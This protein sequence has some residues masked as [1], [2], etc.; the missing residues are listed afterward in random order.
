M[1]ALLATLTKPAPQ[2]TLDQTA[3]FLALAKMDIVMPN[4]PETEHVL[5]VSRTNGLESTAISLALVLTD[6]A[7]DLPRV[8]FAPPETTDPCANLAI[9]VT[10]TATTE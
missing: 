4:V 8:A 1:L 2:D 3:R 6:T 9:V 7:L 10:C 5:R